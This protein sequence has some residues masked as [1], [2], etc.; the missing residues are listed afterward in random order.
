MTPYHFLL[1][2]LGAT[3]AAVAAHLVQRRRRR[4]A[5]Q[6]LARSWQMHYSSRD[7]FQLAAQVASRLPEFGAADVTVLDVIYGNEADSHRYI[8]SAEYTLGVVQAK[9]RVVRVGGL[10]ERKGSHGA[11]GCSGLELADPSVPLLEQYRILHDRPIEPAA[12]PPGDNPG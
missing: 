12:A 7:L 11:S 2:V 8:F 4:R 5:L 6:E 3:A 1:L 9:H 10:R